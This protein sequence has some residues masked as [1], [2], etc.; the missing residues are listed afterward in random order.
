MDN[1]R[2]AVVVG[3]TLFDLGYPNHQR[4]RSGSGRRYSGGYTVARESRRA[5]IW[6]PN[7]THQNER[8]IWQNRTDI[9]SSATNEAISFEY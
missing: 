9:Q 3:I 4:A 5:S 2:L 7:P 8:P 1:A 6:P